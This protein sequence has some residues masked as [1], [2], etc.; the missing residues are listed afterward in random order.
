LVSDLYGSCKCCMGVKCCIVCSTK[1]FQFAF[2]TII[3][4]Q[5]RTI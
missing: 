1:L 2:W 3:Y 4:E 5:F